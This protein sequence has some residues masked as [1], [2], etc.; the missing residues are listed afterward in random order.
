MTEE[1]RHG[2]PRLLSNRGRLERINE[3]LEAETRY[4]EKIAAQAAEIARLRALLK[5]AERA[6]DDHYA[7][8]DCYATGPLTGNRIADFVECPACSFLATLAGSAAP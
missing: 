5:L 8:N 3:L 4:C 6:L 7:P 2:D 1:L